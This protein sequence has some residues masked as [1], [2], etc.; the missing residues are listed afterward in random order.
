MFNNCFHLCTTAL[1]DRLICADDEDYKT[2]WNALAVCAI[3]TKIKIYCLCLM[4]THLHIL[5]AAPADRISSFFHLF[6]QRLG[7][8]YKNRNRRFP[9]NILEYE[10]FPIND[11]KAFCRETAYI[12]RN[13]YKAG[14][15]GPF[16]YRW[17]SACA[18]FNPYLDHGRDRDSFSCNELRAMLK[19]RYSLPGTVRLIDEIIAPT[20]LVDAAF[21]ER[22]FNDSSILFFNMIRNWSLEAVVRESHGQVVPEAYSD[23]EVQ[24]EIS[25]LCHNM[26]RVN[27]PSHLDRKALGWLVRKIHARFGCSRGQLL[28]LLPVDDFFLEQIL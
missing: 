15:S 17:S 18:Y 3:V 23:N 14:I 10:L 19:T 12:I 1:K 28:R 7:I 13:P 8:I 26:L 20:S 27:S 4:S 2:V 9:L 21:V 16:A 5:L 25:L 11:R 22:M 24:R 6:K